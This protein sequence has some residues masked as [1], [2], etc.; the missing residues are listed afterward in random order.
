MPD[1][2][3]LRNIWPAALEV[4][5]LQGRVVEAGD[6]IDV[7]GRLVTDAVEV[8]RLLGQPEGQQ[9]APLADD[10]TYIAHPTGN[11]DAPERLLAW[12]A[13][14]WQQVTTPAAPPAKVKE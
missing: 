11:P 6:T 7:A 2:V 13:A 3:K 1:L 8:H 12:P 10:A 9:P 14:V 5:F 4:D